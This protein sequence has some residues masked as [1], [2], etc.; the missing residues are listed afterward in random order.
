[1]IELSNGGPRTRGIKRSATGRC[2]RA[3]HRVRLT[4]DISKPDHRPMDFTDVSVAQEPLTQPHTASAKRPVTEL[5]RPTTVIEAPRLARRL[6]CNAFLATETFQRTGSFKFR[7]ASNLVSGIEH[8]LVITASSGNFGQALAHACTLAGKRS[9][10][11]M[12][13]TSAAVKIEAVREYGGE[14][15]LV[16]TRVKSRAERLVRLHAIIR[17]LI[18][19]ARTTTRW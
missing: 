7:A 4:P 15:V 19:R 12:P 17:K 16:D 1:M 8:E 14:V 5:V 11:V 18:S 10:I 2:W 6:G 9:M 13:H 3:E